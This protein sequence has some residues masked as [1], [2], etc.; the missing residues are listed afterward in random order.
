ML[1]P[2]D[3]LDADAVIICSLLRQSGEMWHAERGAAADAVRDDDNKNGCISEELKKNLLDVLKTQ[4]RGVNVDSLET[5]YTD[6]IGTKLDFRKHGFDN[7]LDMLKT[8]KEI[9]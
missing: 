9:R 4:H 5:C 2:P 7:L 1:V 6:K 3:L 8:V